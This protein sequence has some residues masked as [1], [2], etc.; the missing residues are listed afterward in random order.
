MLLK[1][2]NDRRKKC[3]GK[4]GKNEGVEFWLICSRPLHFFPHF[5]PLFFRLSFLFFQPGSGV[6]GAP[7][8]PH[9]QKHI[10]HPLS[11]AEYRLFYWALLQK[12]PIILSSTSHIRKGSRLISDLFFMSFIDIFPFPNL[13]PPLNPPHTQKDVA[14]GHVSY[15]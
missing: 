1:K 3:G 13:C 2:R 10:A 9:T 15:E 11:F 12:R 14:H 8:P 7:H 4:W 6:I 5:P